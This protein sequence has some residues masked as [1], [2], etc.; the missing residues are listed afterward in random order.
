MILLIIHWRCFSG[1]FK[2]KAEPVSPISAFS[3]IAIQ[4]ASFLYNTFCCFRFTT[5][6]GLGPLI[7]MIRLISFDDARAI[8]LA[9]H[10]GLILPLSF[11][12]LWQSIL[13][14][15]QR[16]FIQYRCTR[17]A[18]CRIANI[19]ITTGETDYYATFSLVRK[20]PCYFLIIITSRSIVR[21]D[22]LPFEAGIHWWAWISKSAEEDIESFHI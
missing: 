19:S 1:I 5:F 14:P 21:D 20:L 4:H 22:R 16:W 12:L 3:F 9:G 18:A 2:I 7:F 15:S 6:E 13:L 8:S 17:H 11:R 10:F